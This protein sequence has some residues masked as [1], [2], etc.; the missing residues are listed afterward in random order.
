MYSTKT[1]K[2]GILNDIL[3]ELDDYDIYRHY[4][5]EFTVGKLYNSPF[6]ED[7]KIPSFAVFRGRNGGLMF[8]D[9]G[10]GLSGNVV[11]FV[12]EYKHITR[13]GDLEKELLRILR[14]QA[15]KSTRGVTREYTSYSSADI[16]IVRQ[17]FTDTDIDYWNQYNIDTE[18]LK[19]F[20]V[21]SIKYFLCNNIVSG[22]YKDSNPMYAYKIDDKFKIYRPF[23]TKYTKWRTNVTTENI[24][25]LKQLPKGQRNL[26]IVTKSLK[27]VMV[28]YKMGYDAI[29]PSS[30]TTFLPTK[31]LDKLKKKYKH[32]LILYDRD[33]TG[34]LKARTYSKEYG[35]DAFFVNKKFN[36][37]DISDAV[38][39]CGFDTVKEWL[40]KTLKRYDSN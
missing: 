8:K 13:P 23:N 14:T 37:K 33:R 39:S 3:K 25:G 27:D 29:S 28:L 2:L 4:L 19:K 17:P 34:M 38:A 30:E 20:Q 18:T 36:S 9:H 7:D 16:G 22:V 6:R 11:T 40:V 32:I 1:A 31:I 12:K 21:F 10:I 5:G 35:L 26:L 24:Q 15:P